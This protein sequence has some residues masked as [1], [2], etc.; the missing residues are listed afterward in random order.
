MQETTRREQHSHSTSHR[1]PRRALVH[2][3][4]KCLIFQIITI[5]T[6]D[7]PKPDWRF[8]VY[9]RCDLCFRLRVFALPGSQRARTS[10]CV[11]LVDR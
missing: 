10:A 2:N 5:A 11:P 8:H 3:T 6:P 4:Q 9:L 1:T 7:I